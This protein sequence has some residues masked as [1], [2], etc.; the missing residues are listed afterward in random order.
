[1]LTQKQQEMREKY[2]SEAIRY[3][4]NVRECL[5]KAKKEGKFYHDQKYVKAAC[6]I[7]YSGMRVALDCFPM[8]K[9]VEKPRGKIRKSIQYYQGNITRIDGKMLNTLNGAYK[10][11]HLWGYYDGIEVVT[12]VKDS[13]DLALA[14]IEKINPSS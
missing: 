7:A 6:G 13:F 8:L 3:M 4:D 2:Y 10:I 11:L 5:A 1:M 12:V 14:I 9:G